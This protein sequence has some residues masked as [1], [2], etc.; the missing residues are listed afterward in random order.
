MRDNNAGIHPNFPLSFCSRAKQSPCQNL[1]PI[2]SL[3]LSS[4]GCR[5]TFNGYRHIVKEEEEEE[6]E[7]EGLVLEPHLAPVE[8]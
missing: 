3:A 5:G 7:E 1:L 4:S 2:L 8:F 6:E